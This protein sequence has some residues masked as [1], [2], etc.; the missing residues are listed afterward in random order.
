MPAAALA[1]LSRPKLYSAILRARLFQRLDQTREHPAIWVCGP[2]GAGKTTLV[3]SYVS[4]RE[5]PGIWYQV[6]SGDGDPATFFYYL[7][8]AAEQAVKG[9]H[10]PLPLLTPEFQHDVDRFSRRHFRALFARLPDGALVVLDNVQEAPADSAFQ[11]ILEALVEEIPEG[12]NVLCLSRTDPPSAF[13]RYASTGRLATVEWADLRL[14]LEETRQIAAVKQPISERTLARLF[15]QSEGWAAGLTLMLERIARTGD[16]PEAIEAETRE[17]VFNYFAGTLFDKQ[18]A[19]TRQVL[20]R[21][22]FLPQIT[23]SLAES[24][25]GNPNAG[26]LLEHLHRRHLFTYRRRLGPPRAQVKKRGSEPDEAAYEYHA[27]FRD[28]LLAKAQEEYTRAGLHRLLE[29]TAQLLE[30]IERDEDAVALYR[31]AEDWGAVTRLLLKQAPRL[32]RQGR[33][34]TLREWI[35]G[36][37]GEEVAARPWISYWLGVSLIPI[38]QLEAIG[39]LEQAFERFTGVDDPIGQ[40]ACAARIIE[41]IYRGYVNYKP[42]ERWIDVLDTLLADGLKISDQDVELRAYCSLVLATVSCSPR[43]PRLAPSVERVS[44]LLAEGLE[45]DLLVTAGDVLLRSFAWAADVPNGRRVIGLVDRV[46]EDKSVAQ[47]AQLYWRA[48][49]GMFNI[50]DGRYAAAEAALRKADEIAVNFGSHTATVLVH[51]FWVFLRLAQRDVEEAERHVGTMLQAITPGRASD[52]HLCRFAQS[53]LA[54]HTDTP[55]RAMRGRSRATGSEHARRALLRGDVWNRSTRGAARSIGADERSRTPRCQRQ[56][57]DTRH[58]HEPCRGPVAA[59]AGVMRRC[60]TDDRMRARTLMD[61]ATSMN[62]DTNLFVL[63]LIP[64]VLPCGFRLRSARGNRRSQDQGLDRAL[65]DCSR[66]SGVRAL[67]VGGAGSISWE[68]YAWCATTSLCC[69]R[70]RP[71]RSPW[72]CSCS[73]RRQAQAESRPGWSQIVYGQIWKVMRLQPVS[74]RTCT[75]CAS[76]WESRMHCSAPR[77]ASRSTRCAVGWTPGR[78]SN[79]PRTAC[80]LPGKTWLKRRAR[81]WTSTRATFWIGKA[82][83]RGR[84]LFAS[85]SL[86][87]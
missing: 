10:R 24:L 31:A 83:I 64:N 58:L 8:L 45:P 17:A 87:A 28:F 47:L 33:A 65:S 73:W 14:T 41:A 85:N 60:G 43:H 35:A 9:K 66:R 63:R 11:S 74:T 40:I 38:D 55:E 81:R 1:K 4:E 69:S 78:S 68:V 27:L 71:R 15:E 3:A 82:S 23:P 21:T 36:V 48:R 30:T 46:V 50:S 59:R 39:R 72:S 26:K 18:P 22:A 37:P 56:R 53:L 6:D 77:A 25:T 84:W 13:A 5:I 49:V 61:S 86:D 34:Q 42:V 67:A 19:D 44:R 54:A 20:L 70:E 2:P 79:S 12:V 62:V 80:R 32:L 75:V 52:L 7:G 76:C 29:E 16:V 57:G 51:L